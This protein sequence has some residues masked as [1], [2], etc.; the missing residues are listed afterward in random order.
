MLLQQA[1]TQQMLQPPGNQNLQL[2]LLQ[3]QVQQQQ[4]Q[5]RY[6][7]SLRNSIL[8]PS[9]L[10]SHLNARLNPGYSAL[11]GNEPLPASFALPSLMMS[12]P[13]PQS[14]PSMYGAA[15]M[16]RPQPQHG[17]S[18]AAANKTS[19]KPSKTAYAQDPVMSLEEQEKLIRGVDI[20]ELD[21]PAPLLRPGDEDSLSKPQV[22]L[23]DQIEVFKA[24]KD[25]AWTHTRGR[26]KPVNVGQVGIRCRHCAHLPANERQKGSTYFPAAL[27]GLYQAAQNMNT[28]HMQTGICS[29]MPEEIKKQFMH[30][31]SGKY[32][33]SGA[34]RPFWADSARKLGVVDT[35][36][37]MRFIRDVKI[38]ASNETTVSAQKSPK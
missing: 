37:G 22:F 9:L 15:G 33:S 35:E 1:Q 30:Q 29:Q 7:E 32:S 2:L 18:A 34:G 26:N 12:S 25:D 38:P 11:L 14:L 17:V 13:M 36:E 16:N 20:D 27:K 21:L 28:T 23:R 8:A 5:T 6:L 10:Q 3:Q 4:E 31:V 24:G 19:P